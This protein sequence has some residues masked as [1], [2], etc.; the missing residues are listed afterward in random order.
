MRTAELNEL[1]ERSCELFDVNTEMVYSMTRKREPTDMRHIL[2]FTIKNNFPY[3]SLKTIGNLFSRRDHTSV[4]HAISKSLNCM[5]TDPYYRYMVHEV[6]AIAD[7]IK[8]KFGG[9]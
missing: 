3:L 6:Q 1:I 8:N 9:N 5:Q 2:M 7:Q 4:I